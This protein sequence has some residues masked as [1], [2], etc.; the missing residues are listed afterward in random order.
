MI[1]M[2]GGKTMK[3]TLTKTLSLILAIL[4]T[5]S[6][7]TVSFAV[8]ATPI[9]K[10]EAE[11]KALEYIRYNNCNSIITDDVYSDAE[12]VNKAI[13]KVTSLVT[14]EDNTAVTYVAYVDKYDGTVYNR[15][16]NFIKPTLN[17]TENEAFQLALK[18]L[19]ANEEDIVVFKRANITENGEVVGYS[20][21]FVEDF[22]VKHKCN[23]DAK[24]G[25]IDNIVIVEPVNIIDRIILMIKVLFTRLLGV[26]IF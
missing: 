18:A 19:C 15:T 25:F 5:F 11:V 20:Y 3:K 7:A 4:L 21:E 6:V 26:T 12:N 23:V 2:K 1:K 16:A 24:T 10:E 13:Y 22:Y 17:L 8:D 14:L 9:A